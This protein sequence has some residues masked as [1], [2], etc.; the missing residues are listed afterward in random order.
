MS[1]SHRDFA[2]RFRDGF[3]DS[4]L[5]LQF[6]L[7]HHGRKFGN[8]E[9]SSTVQHPLL[10]EGEWLDSTEI[11]QILKDFSHMEDRTGAHLLRV[12]LE[13]VFPIFL[14]KERIIAEEC[15]E[16]FD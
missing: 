8:K 6:G 2:A 11:Y 5:N 4:V 3:L 15:N 16:L 1:L 7:I 10:A 14:S 13:A 9:E 12:F